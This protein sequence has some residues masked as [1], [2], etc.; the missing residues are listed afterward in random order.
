MKPKNESYPNP[1]KTLSKSVEYD[2]PWIK[3]T[4][5]KVINPAGGDGIYGVVHFKSQ[6]IGVVPLDKDYNTYLVGQYRY[7]LDEYSW[8][9]PEGGSPLGES[10]LATAKRELEE[11]TGLLADEWIEILKMH[12]SNSVTDEVGYAFVARKLRQGIAQPEDTEDLKVW[13]LPFQQAFEMAMNS[14]ITDSL[15]VISLFK[16]KMLIDQGKL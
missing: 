12:T 5:H 16:V 15:S 14:E 8:E 6:A 13:K 7:A 11:E 4:E 2:N 3:V 10:S 9:I 1:W